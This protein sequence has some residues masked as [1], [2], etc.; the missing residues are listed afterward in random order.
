M[1]TGIYQEKQKATA[2]KEAI[3]LILQNA[4]VM[5]SH[6]KVALNPSVSAK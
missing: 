2:A 5:V 3:N 6:A 1:V 4:Y